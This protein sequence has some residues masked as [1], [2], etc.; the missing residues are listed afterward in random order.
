MKILVTGGAGFIGSHIVDRY[1]LNGH[2]V[3][4]VDNLSTLLNKNIN[5]EAKFYR[6]DITD[7]KLKDVFKKEKPQIVSHHAAQIDIR[8]S[9]SDPVFDAEVNIVGSLNV[10]QSCVEIGAKKVIFASSGGAVYGDP[11]YMPVDEAHAAQPLSPYGVAKF[12]IENYLIAMRSYLGKLDYTILRYGNVFGPRQNL[13]GEAGVCSI[14][15]G[16]MKNN[17]NCMLYGYGKPIRDYVYVGD[18]AEANLLALTKGSGKIYNIGTGIG[19][20]VSDVFKILKGLT[21]YNKKPLLKS[22]RAGELQKIYLDYSKAKKELGWIPKVF[23][24]E[25]LQK[26]VES[27]A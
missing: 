17:E 27:E 20:T 10:L 23:L 22:L 6:L 2:D 24:K 9:V 19:S 11:E 14:F 12:T 26:L 4:I 7:R 15:L 13:L 18:V 1:I 5:G 16:R 25:G 8:K 21:A 3:V